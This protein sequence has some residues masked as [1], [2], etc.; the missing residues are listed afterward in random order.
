M[1]IILRTSLSPFNLLDII[2]QYF[3]KK[4]GYEKGLISMIC[5]IIEENN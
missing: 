4:V 2:W 1:R 5:Y 3:V